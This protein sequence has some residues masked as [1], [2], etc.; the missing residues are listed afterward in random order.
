MIH[1]PGTRYVQITG[2]PVRDTSWYGICISS[3]G[4]RTYINPDIRVLGEQSDR[5]PGYAPMREKNNGISSC[6][7]RTLD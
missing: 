4:I 6:L 2:T 7:Q 1:I 5:L 3:D